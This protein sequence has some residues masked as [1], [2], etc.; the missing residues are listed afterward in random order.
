M[1][2]P[3]VAA[4]NQTIG[5]TSA[6]GRAINLPSGVTAGD[7]LLA[8]AA[9]DTSVS[10]SATGTWT[11]IDNGANGTAVQGAI[12]ARIATGDS[13]DNL[14]I[15][16]E[17]ND[18]AVVAVRVT[19]HGVSDVS[20]DIKVGTAATGSSAGPNPPSLNAGSSA[21]WLWIAAFAAD[22]DDN[23]GTW[24]PTNYTAILQAESAQSTSSCMV[25]VAYREVEASTEDPGTFAMAATEEWRAQTIAIPPAAAADV[26]IEP[27]A[28][29]LSLTG[30]APTVEATDLPRLYYVIYPSAGSEPSAAQ[31]KAGQDATGSAATAAGDE[32]ARQTT[33]E[34]V[35]A[36][37][38][39]GL[40]AATSYRAAF[41]WS[42][43][44]NDS[45]VAV[46]DA[47]DTLGAG[48]TVSV[49]AASLT[50]SA[51]TPTIV[52]T[53]NVWIDV[54]AAS[55]AL[56]AFAPTVAATANVW[57][58]APAA[59]LSVQGHAPSVLA[60]ASVAVDV[61]SA[62]LALAG[63]APTVDATADVWIEVPVAG[64]TVNAQTPTVAASA[65]VWIDVPSAA[66]GA[67][68]YAPSVLAGGDA[69]IQVPAAAISIVGFAPIV[70]AGESITPGWSE[71]RQRRRGVSAWIAGELHRF[72]SAQELDAAIHEFAQ[73]LPERAQESARSV[74][75][76]GQ[77][78]KRL[79]KAAPIVVVDD[80][81]II[82]VMAKRIEAVNRRARQEYESAIRT[83]MIADLMQ[84]ID[85]E[86]AVVA[87]M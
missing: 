55:L 67:T 66:I 84:S 78:P 52:A 69:A 5:T 54:P 6:S 21:E 29:S 35:F 62:S 43:G 1:A 22:D 12:W 68:A 25:G 58:E 30:Y 46:S 26:V 71:F 36:T 49:P 57:I 41:V 33:G 39:S 37:A 86:A 28:G 83:A 23:T 81:E 32:V 27:P 10:W 7:L 65:N 56:T 77:S 48:E 72:D 76:S 50:L 3:V 17:A 8:F 11:Q 16:G 34:Q 20:T 75:S 9:N 38:A 13:N 2:F 14:T 42:D 51:Q 87:I 80:E 59:S 79:A 82:A 24:W 31:I 64:L 19:G 85:D 73:A 18:I 61:P 44:S 70:I 45:N 74:R 15:T 47:F 63:F 4:S 53:A 40:S 60:G